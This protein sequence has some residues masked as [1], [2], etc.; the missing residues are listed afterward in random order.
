MTNRLHQ[1]QI[2]NEIF[3]FFSGNSWL[4]LLF[5]N[6]KKLQWNFLDRKWIPLPP[7]F[8]KFSE[9]PSIFDK[10]VVPMCTCQ[11]VTQWVLWLF[12]GGVESCAKGEQGHWDKL[13]DEREREGAQQVL[14]VC[15]H[16]LQVSTALTWRIAH[17]SLHSLFRHAR[18]SSTY[19]RMSGDNRCAPVR[20]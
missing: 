4:K 20:W 11:D 2:C 5:L 12:Q 13:L 1:H 18:V 7:P 15:S 8:Q 6:Q 9:N 14:F 3:K 17:F 19:P 16:M 10:T